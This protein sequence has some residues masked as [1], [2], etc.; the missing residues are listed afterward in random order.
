MCKLVKKEVFKAR[1]SFESEIIKEAK[2]NPK[3][4]FK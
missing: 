2:S 4:L 3:V 1:K